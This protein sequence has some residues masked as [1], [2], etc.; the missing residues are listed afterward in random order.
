MS[1]M[2]KLKISKR[3]TPSL[4]SPQQGSIPVPNGH[5]SWAPGHTSG[6][7][8]GQGHFGTMTVGL[9]MT[10]WKKGQTSLEV[11]GLGS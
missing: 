5:P 9:G 8:I 4:P 7:G 10:S 6:L 3:N 1:Q 11:P 2:R